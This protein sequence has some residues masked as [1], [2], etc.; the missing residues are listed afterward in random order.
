[1]KKLLLIIL[2]TCISF[3][4]NA[5]TV[6]YL[7]Q[8]DKTLE[9]VTSANGL[10]YR[11]AGGNTT[12]FGPIGLGA[13]DLSNEYQ[14]IN[15]NSQFTHIQPYFQNGTFGAT[16]RF[17]FAVGGSNVASGNQSVVFGL[18]NLVTGSSSIAT[19]QGNMTTQGFSIVTG[20]ANKLLVGANNNQ[21]MAVFGQGNYTTST[22]GLIA[23]YNNTVK[24]GFQNIIL[25]SSNTVDSLYQNQSGSPIT[26][27]SVGA[28]AATSAKLKGAF[29]LTGATGGAVIEDAFGSSLLGTITDTLQQT[30]YSNIIGGYGN[31]IKGDINLVATADAF[32][33]STYS[34]NIIGSMNSKIEGRNYNIGIYNSFN[35]KMTPSKIRGSNYQLNSVLIASEE[36]SLDTV[37]GALVTGFDNHANNHGQVIMGNLA[38]VDARIGTNSPETRIF[39]IGGGTGTRTTPV[40]SRTRKDV[41][42]V[43]LNGNTYAAG[44]ITSPQFILTDMNTAPA[45]ATA[46]GTKGEIRITETYIYVCVATNTWVRS[47]L[48]TW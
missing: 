1:M 25:G 17:S 9:K 44:S 45:S 35:S 41:F 20:S 27:Q 46:V 24:G 47:A 40:A 36:S 14:A 5:Q 32:K 13:T 26:S 15:G 3:L 33:H 8:N 43:K 37:S 7:T 18:G 21:S 23:G 28:I 4:A 22:R 39:K 38:E 10:G 6:K 48:S 16:G 2:M 12:F 30:S 42:Y 19:G 34:S 29:I 11:L 31:K